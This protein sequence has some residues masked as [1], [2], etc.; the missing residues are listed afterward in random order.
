MLMLVISSIIGWYAL[1][2]HVAIDENKLE[3]TNLLLEQQTYQMQ[4]IQSIHY[5]GA[6]GEYLITFNDNSNINTAYLKP[7]PLEMIAL[8]AAESGKRVIR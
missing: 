5:L 8:L 3:I 1:R 4:E 7:V 2:W 6:E